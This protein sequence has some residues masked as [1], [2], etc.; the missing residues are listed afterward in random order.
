[1]S[2]LQPLSWKEVE[3]LA[4]KLR[5]EIQGYFVERISVPERPHSRGGFIKNEWLIRLSGRKE[6]RTLVFSVRAR[7]PY[8]ALYS[9]KGPKAAIQATQPVFALSLNKKLKGARLIEIEAVPR[10]RSLI[11]WFSAEEKLGLVLS[12]FPSSPEA[13]LVQTWSGNFYPV[14]F[15]TRNV[16][17]NSAKY[18]PPDGSKAP[19]DA[20]MR[21]ELLKSENAWI[22]QIESFNEDESFE[23]RYKDCEREIKS[24]IK[25]TRERLR[26]NKTAL[27]EA[28]KESNWQ[29]YGD[30]LKS[31]LSLSP[32]L[33]NRKWRVEDFNTGEMF[34]VPCDPKLSISE[35]VEKFY[36]LARRKK[37]RIEEAKL[38]VEAL[39]ENVA[40]LEL[41]LSA[42]P[43]TSVNDWTRLAKLEA[44][45]QI[46]L[47]TA[48]AQGQSA[49]KKKKNAW[50][51][52]IFTSKD[53]IPIYLGRSKDENLELTFKHARGNDMWLHVRGKPGAH[54][55]IPVSS[56]KSIPLETILDAANLVIFYS[57][58]ENWGK[59]EVDYT[60]K[61]FVKRIKDSTEVSYTNNKTLM[62][63]PDKKRIRLFLTSQNS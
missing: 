7:A 1:M 31:S 54:A 26:Q 57:G 55:V 11:L 24:L 43:V 25:Q 12:L 8:I 51:G 14:L 46:E 16:K 6:E 47:P 49:P 30:L 52:K 18:F 44:L 62:I 13:L 56:G 10:D 37:R 59:T 9:S 45:A 42:P 15:R 38:R 29:R 5:S 19:S 23:L 41:S 39:A 3:Y 17:Q 35:Q 4:G 20:P 32:P 63:E 53:G 33:E 40:R 2:A 34:D 28:E 36:S 60:Y 21:E 27:S 58:G 50:L 61:K 48:P 22:R